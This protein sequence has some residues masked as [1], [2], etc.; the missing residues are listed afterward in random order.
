MS[1]ALQ[2]LLSLEMTGAVFSGP[3]YWCNSDFRLR[4]LDTPMRGTH[5]DNLK[6]INQYHLHRKKESIWQL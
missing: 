4:T 1:L 2:S 5:R 6:M 3:S